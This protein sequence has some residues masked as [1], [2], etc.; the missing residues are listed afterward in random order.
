MPSG[1]PALFM[2]PCAACAGLAAFAREGK[3]G[4]E[5]FC[6]RKD[7][8]AFGAGGKAAINRASGKSAG[9]PSKSGFFFRSCSLKVPGADFLFRPKE[10]RPGFA[11]AIP[12]FFSVSRVRL[13]NRRHFR[14]GI[15]QFEEGALSAAESP[16]RPWCRKTG[17]TA[18]SQCLPLLGF[19]SCRPV[20]SRPAPRFSRFPSEIF[21]GFDFV[22]KS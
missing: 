12:L 19:P 14:S 5:L 15:H 22:P 10:K 18:L 17:M 3:S 11:P 8:K 9:R 13:P 7:G 6:R 2:P 4:E 16:F 21:P 20:R 1:D